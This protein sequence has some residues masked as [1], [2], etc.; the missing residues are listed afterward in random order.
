MIL[1]LV[2]FPLSVAQTNSIQS[3]R[4]YYYIIHGINRFELLS[5]D[6]RVRTFSENDWTTCG[7]NPR[8]VSS[9]FLL[10]RNSISLTM[11][12]KTNHSVVFF[13]F[14]FFNYIQRFTASVYHRFDHFFT[15][16]G[17]ISIE[18]VWKRSLERYMYFTF[19]RETENRG[20]LEP[21]RSTADERRQRTE[22]SAVKGVR[23]RLAA[24]TV[25]VAVAVAVAAIP[26]SIA[27]IATSLV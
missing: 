11:N 27:A 25:T 10:S 15:L 21:S 5:L 13:L 3:I 18:I 20:P 1:K 6:N 22:S 17:N 26:P 14:F 16:S 4:N 2:E 24:A 7:Y 9:S 12:E 8:C 23:G 19:A